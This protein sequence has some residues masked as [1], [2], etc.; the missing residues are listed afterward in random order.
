LIDKQ[1][2]YNKTF[3]LLF[4]ANEWAPHLR[5]C[6]VH[7]INTCRSR[8]ASWR[9]C[10]AVLIRLISVWLVSGYINVQRSVVSVTAFSGGGSINFAKG[11]RQRITPV[12]VR[13]KCT[14]WT[15][16]LLHIKRPLT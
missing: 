9:A 6:W 1:I 11:G 14:Q 5:L 12:V 15:I 4:A 2:V 13:R 8:R 3:A 16:S 10:R 7:V